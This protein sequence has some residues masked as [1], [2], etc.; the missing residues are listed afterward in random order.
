M[1]H[2]I[3]PT[4]NRALG[5]RDL[6]KSIFENNNNLKIKLTLIDASNDI[7]EQQQNLS[8]LKSYN[9]ELIE[10]IPVDTN[11]LW[12]RCV[13]EGIRRVQPDQE[14]IVC[15]MNDDITVDSKFFDFYKKN[16]FIFKNHIVSCNIRDGE[17]IEQRTQIYKASIK[18]LKILPF[19]VYGKNIEESFGIC[20]AGRGL[21]IPSMDLHLDIYKRINLFP[22]Y[23]GD[24]ILTLRL[25]NKKV[26][27]F[28]SHDL[29]VKGKDF[30]RNSKI[31]KKEFL[32][33]K[34]M[35]YIPALISFWLEII[36][37]NLSIIM[38]RIKKI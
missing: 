22:H 35:S 6:V 32:N 21:F 29:Y 13:L 18:K 38:D 26:R 34:S 20:A 30:N 15:L 7:N 19:N 11:F 1:L 27:F 25:Y 36:I 37:G 33:K 16:H 31:K 2:I 9:K 3:I 28:Q 23:L 4:Y 17:G 14:N 24:L 12:T 10:I 8:L 5:L